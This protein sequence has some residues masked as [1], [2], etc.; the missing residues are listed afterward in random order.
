MI[1]PFFQ[2]F[3][4]AKLVS[5]VYLFEIALVIV[6]SFVISEELSLNTG[7]VDVLFNIKLSFLQILSD[8]PVTIKVKSLA[9]VAKLDPTKPRLNAQ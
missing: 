3:V 9:G 2:F 8:K 4:G 1:H 6:I 5:S 7:I